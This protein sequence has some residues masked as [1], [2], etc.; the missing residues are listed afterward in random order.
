MRIVRQKSKTSALTLIE[1]LFV[2]IIGG[3]LIASAVPLIKA[4]KGRAE[5]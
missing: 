5:S 3:V 4:F 1:I 2:I